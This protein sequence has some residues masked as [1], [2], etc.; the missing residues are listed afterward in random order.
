MKNKIKIIIVFVVMSLLMTKTTLLA[1]DLNIT[2]ELKQV[3]N[4]DMNGKELIQADSEYKLVF[5]KGLGFDG[6]IYLS[7]KGKYDNLMNKGEFDL[8][9]AF[10]VLYFP[11]TD[12]TFG[13]QVINW[14]TADGI[15]PTNNVNPIDIASFTEGKL[16]GEPVLSVQ[17]SYFGEN[18]DITAVLIFD[19]LPQ[20]LADM[21]SYLGAE[22]NLFANLDINSPKNN[23]R[24]MEYALKIGRRIS[25]YDL[26]LSYFHGWE[27]LP[28]KINVNLDNNYQP[29]FTTLKGSY[30]QVDKYGIAIAGAINSM[31][32]WG[33][34]AYVNPRSIDL[35]PTNPTGIT[36]LSTM[37]TPY[38]QAVLGSDYTFYNGVYVGGQYIYYE[39]G[40][41]FNPYHEG[42][43]KDNDVKAGQYIMGRAS[44][45]FNKSNI[46]LTSLFNL[47]DNSIVI[48]PTY[49]RSLNPVTDLKISP[50]IPLGEENSELQM[51]NRQLKV[52]IETSF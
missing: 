51:L 31:G 6:D 33:E 38:L 11:T 18:V 24:K 48:M 27:D 21:S 49:I 45:K 30:R 25:S 23:L 41:I 19:F 12:L 26:K 29:D 3:L 47:K 9:E 35:A 50:I 43:I 36:L 16:T 4:Y 37:N 42:D 28:A 32:V 39:N 20:N 2:G 34:L 46:E 14:G 8:D 17:A 1:S 15:N 10:T 5:R 22:G 44:Y 52:S 40:S 13:K 7:L